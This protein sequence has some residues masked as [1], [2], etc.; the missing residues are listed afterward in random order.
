VVGD[1]V[2]ANIC[3]L[4]EYHEY[5]FESSGIEKQFEQVFAV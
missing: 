4:I 5:M 3:S 2:F 1:L